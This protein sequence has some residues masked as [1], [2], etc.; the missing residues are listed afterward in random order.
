MNKIVGLKL[1]TASHE[2]DQLETISTDS[3]GEIRDAQK[4]KSPQIDKEEIVR[5][6][7]S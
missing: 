5:G 6:K 2:V 3:G 1:Q 7:H 4:N